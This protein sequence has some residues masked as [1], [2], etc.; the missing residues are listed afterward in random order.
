MA[1]PLNACSYGLALIA[2]FKSVSPP[3]L[4]PISYV[5]TLYETG[6]MR[7]TGDQSSGN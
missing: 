1:Y 4:S 6:E 5:G 7:A 2:F 3:D